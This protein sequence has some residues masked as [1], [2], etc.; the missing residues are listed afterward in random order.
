MTKKVAVKT[1]PRFKVGEV[2][3]ALTVKPTKEIVVQAIDIEV[4]G[5]VFDYLVVSLEEPGPTYHQF[6]IEEGRLRKAPKLVTLIRG[7][8][9]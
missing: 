8:R 5:E 2:L 7:M 1:K 4:V 3:V 9:I 6:W